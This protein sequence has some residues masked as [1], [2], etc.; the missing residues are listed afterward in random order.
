VAGQPALPNWH[1]LQC[2]HDTTRA[3]RCRISQQARLLPA[4]QAGSWRLLI[5][6]MVQ[7]PPAFPLHALLLIIVRAPWLTPT[8]DRRV[9]GPLLMLSLAYLTLLAA[10][11]LADC[12]IIDGKRQRTYTGAGGP[13]LLWMHSPF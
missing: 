8:V 1:G 4:S 12:Y 3:G 9:A 2:M 11:L 7:E 10:Q 13:C 6:H 5:N